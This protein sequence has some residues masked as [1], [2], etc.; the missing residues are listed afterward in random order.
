MATVGLNFWQQHF[1]VNFQQDKST[2]WEEGCC[3]HRTDSPLLWASN[4]R[5]APALLSS[6]QENL[7][8][9][10]KS[11]PRSFSHFILAWFRKFL[12]CFGSEDW[13]LNPGF[14]SPAGQVAVGVLFH[15][16]C[17]RT[18]GYFWVYQ[19]VVWGITL[20]EHTGKGKHWILAGDFPF[21]NKILSR[22][23]FGGVA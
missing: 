11:T 16:P 1:C 22:Q 4:S 21:I 15:T 3:L 7:P 18:P 20:H 12:C 5:D 14:V 2:L 10:F 23:F 13:L 6:S 9:P 19:N 8:S 17:C